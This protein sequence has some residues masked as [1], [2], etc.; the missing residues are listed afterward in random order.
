MAGEVGGA[1]SVRC[2]VAAVDLDVVT[3]ARS[4]AEEV[5]WPDAGEIDRS[6]NVPR[7]VLD[8]LAEAGLYGLVGPRVAGGAD[9]SAE[10]CASVIE[11][12]G[13]ASLASAFVW[14]QHHSTVRVVAG[15]RPAVR[16]QWLPEL[17]AGRVRS[18][19]AI[20]AL[21]RPGPPSM[22]AA[23]TPDG[24]VRL[25]GSAP[26]VTGWG[27]V[28]VIM[29]AAREGDDLVWALI[30]AVPAPTLRS[31]RLRLAAVDASSTVLLH[32]D[33]HPVPPERVLWREGY[34]EWRSRDAA[35]LG[36]NGALAIGVAAR[37]ASLLAAKEFP[38]A[39]ELVGEV[40]RC[41]RRLIAAP[42][43]GIVAARTACSLLA[44]RAATALV[45]AG[46]GRSVEVTDPAQRLAREAMFLLVFGQTRDIRAAQLEQLLPHR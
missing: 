14:V 18:G 17:C 16:D 24:A 40:D 41:R 23:S 11:A 36:T 3:A 33:G 21:R 10:E 35:G 27:L 8:R 39:D 25:T 1:G 32:L 19:I 15:A 9:A 5:L 4:I 20:G 29:V 42:A 38:G 34:A 12:L 6:P 7:A 44:V 46:G 31:D 37:S 13:G 30:D 22:V 28:D 45:A 26:W 43:D 2:G